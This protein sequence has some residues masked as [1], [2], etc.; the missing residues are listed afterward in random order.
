MAW[1]GMEWNGMDV[2]RAHQKTEFVP[3]LVVSTRLKI[4]FFGTLPYHRG[5]S[6]LPG[7]HLSTK[8][9]PPRGRPP[10]GPRFQEFGDFVFITGRM[11]RGSRWENWRR[12]RHDRM[13]VRDV[14]SPCYPSRTGIV[15][16]RSLPYY[17]LYDVPRKEIHHPKPNQ[18][19]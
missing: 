11:A 19:K 5:P 17:T 3:S 7:I 16:C 18:N 6:S 4:Y 9:Q 1:N 14:A 12:L 15:V 13:G 10:P 2:V 8:F